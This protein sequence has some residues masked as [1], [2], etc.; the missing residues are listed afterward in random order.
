[1]KV[2]QSLAEE[3]PSS[4]LHVMEMDLSSLDSVRSFAKSFNSS[5]RHLNVLMYV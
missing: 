3:I 5:Y 2:K 4:K 1:M